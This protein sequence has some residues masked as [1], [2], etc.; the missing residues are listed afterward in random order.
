MTQTKRTLSNSTCAKEHNRTDAE[1]QEVEKEEEAKV[2]PKQAQEMKNQ[3]CRKSRP[4][5]CVDGNMFFRPSRLQTG[6]KSRGAR[7]A[8]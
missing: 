1:E 8:E 5:F 6:P 2:E 4:A 3:F 7:I